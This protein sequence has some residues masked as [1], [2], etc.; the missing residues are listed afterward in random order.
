MRLM[1]ADELSEQ[2]FDAVSLGS[3]VQRAATPPHHRRAESASTDRIA[4][5][6]LPT[7]AARRISN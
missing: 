7:T 1:L 2:G 4:L 5:P 3:R 6:C